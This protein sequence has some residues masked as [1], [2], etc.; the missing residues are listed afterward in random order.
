MGALS[1]YRDLE[2][3]KKALTLPEMVYRVSLPIPADERSGTTGQVRRATVSV[4]SNIAAGTGRHGV[5]VVSALS[6]DSQRVAGGNGGYL[7]LGSALEFG[8]SRPGDAGACAS[9]GSRPDADRAPALT[10]LSHQAANH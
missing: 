10:Q 7:D 9:S 5:Q 1:S 2:V 3:G 8:G 6:G 4:A